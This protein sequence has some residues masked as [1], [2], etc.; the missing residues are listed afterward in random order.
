MLRLLALAGLLLPTAAHAVAD[1]C[2]FVPGGCPPLDPAGSV[3]PLVVMYMLRIAV[4]ISLLAILWAC[5]RILLSWGDEGKITSAR[6]AILFSLIGMATAI[7]SQVFISVV[8]GE[9]RVFGAI[10]PSDFDLQAMAQFVRIMV[11]VFNVL[12]G[13][14]G[15]VAGVRMLIARGKEDQYTQAR[16]ILVW[17][18]I[19][20]IIVNVSAFVLQIVVSSFE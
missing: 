11:R 14:V 10:G 7:L 6:H 1:P 13:F 16:M 12:M 2:V 3:I 9:G 18:I 17:S 8:A 4:G 5:Y 20:A 19:A 15:F